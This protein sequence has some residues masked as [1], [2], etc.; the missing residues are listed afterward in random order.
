MAITSCAI[1]D[2]SSASRAVEFA[3]CSRQVAREEMRTFHVGGG[4]YGHAMLA[5]DGKRYLDR[6]RRQVTNTACDGHAV[7][8][9]KVCHVS[10]VSDLC[11]D[12]YIVNM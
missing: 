2:A 7:L 1:G 4:Q 12:V 5:Q 3:M 11:I 8:H 10:Y 9:L 6:F